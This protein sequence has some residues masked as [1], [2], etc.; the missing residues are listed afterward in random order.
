M[1]Y[2][3]N[4]HQKAA[5]YRFRDAAHRRGHRPP[6]AGQGAQLQQH[7]RHRRRLRAG[8]RVRPGRRPGRAPSSSTPTPAAWPSAADLLE[9]YERALACDPVSAFGGIV[10][11]NRPPGRA[12]PPR[13]WSRSSPR[14]SSRPEADDDAIA[15]FAA[16]KNLRLLVTGGLPDPLA[17]GETFKS[18]AG[19]F[20]VQGRDT[21][22]ITAADLKIV[23]K[24]AADRRRRCATCC[25]PSPSPST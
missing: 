10:A 4:P 8:R 14:W 21:A 1:R 7:Q 25:S 15:V 3:E 5:F 18:V 24:R 22:R 23:T 13:R 12:P 19:G 9:A 16:K 6:A 20:L 2:G 11:V 17:P